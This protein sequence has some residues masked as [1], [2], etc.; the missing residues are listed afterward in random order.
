MLKKYHVSFS[1]AKNSFLDWARRKSQESE[2]GRRNLAVYFFNL[3]LGFIM[4]ESQYSEVTMASLC[5]IKRR[6]ER[7]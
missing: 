2:K 6:E 3:H 1:V 5:G 4:F 7:R